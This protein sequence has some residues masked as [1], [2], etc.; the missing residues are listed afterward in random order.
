[1]KWSWSPLAIA[2]EIHELALEATVGPSTLAVAAVSLGSVS[3][4]VV[5][6]RMREGSHYKRAL[7]ALPAGAKVRLVGPLGNMTLHEDP[8]SNTGMLVSDLVGNHI[9]DPLQ[10]W[11]VAITAA[12]DPNGSWQ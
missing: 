4:L 2:P 5:A 1:M 9:T 6:T 7:K 10:V 12:T 3:R 8:A 11:G